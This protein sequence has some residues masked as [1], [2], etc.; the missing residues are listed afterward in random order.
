MS[1]LATGEKKFHWLKSNE[2]L[3]LYLIDTSSQFNLVKSAISN[4]TVKKSI[5]YDLSLPNKKTVAPNQ[6]D[7][8]E[9]DDF[10]SKICDVKIEKILLNNPIKIDLD[11]FIDNYGKY[12]NLFRS[13][14][15]VLGPIYS[16]L[17]FK[18]PN[19]FRKEQVVLFTDHNS[20]NCQLDLPQHYFTQEEIYLVK[21]LEKIS[22][23]NSLPFDEHEF[24]TLFFFSLYTNI[25]E[26]YAY[27]SFINK[28][29]Y[30]KRIPL[31]EITIRSISTTTIRS[32]VKFFFYYLHYFYNSDIHLSHA[33]SII[34]CYKKKIDKCQQTINMFNHNGMIE[35]KDECVINK[36]VKLFPCILNK[37]NHYC[38]FYNGSHD[39]KIKFEYEDGVTAEFMLSKKLFKFTCMLEKR[40]KFVKVDS[41]VPVFLGTTTIDNVNIL[42]ENAT[43]T[44]IQA[45]ALD[46]KKFHL[47]QFN[48]QDEVWF[49]FPKCK[50]FVNMLANFV[51]QPSLYAIEAVEYKYLPSYFCT[52]QGLNADYYFLNFCN[53][54]Y[55]LPD[56]V[57][58]TIV[59]FKIDLSQMPKIS[60]S[61]P[62]LH[63]PI[64][65]GTFV[66]TYIF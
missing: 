66:G 29:H 23:F 32:L 16:C 51:H 31:P 46:T 36:K 34:T 22:N 19:M 49:H 43:S 1:L 45:F 40:P 56:Y 10:F 42:I 11:Y 24:W 20:I 38:L 55:N 15:F 13:C 17:E 30:E 4:I 21:S 61:E 33:K 28:W 50:K 54:N 60:A 44:Y 25:I 63:T 8:R 7:I 37:L 62:I 53:I 12:D 6:Y 59:S 26:D 41:N 14:L 18:R 5:R 27:K 39:F 35:V 64:Q 9:S 57:A 52:L 58:D 2:K 48:N 3:L 47:L 65:L